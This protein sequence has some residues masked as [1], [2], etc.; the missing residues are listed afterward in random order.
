MKNF[1]EVNVLVVGDIM[2][3]RYIC[4]TV[5]RISPE[6]PVPIVHVTEEYSTLGGSGNVVRNMRSLGANV[7]CLASIAVDEAGKQI[8]RYLEELKVDRKI[9]TASPVTIVKERIVAGERK[10]QMLRVDREIP[11]SIDSERAINAIRHVDTKFDVVV[12]SDYNKGLVSPELMEYLRNRY[13]TII[14]DPKP[15]N[16]HSYGKVFLMTPNKGEWHSMLISPVKAES[17]YFLVTKG[18][19]GM[20]LIDARDPDRN[21]WAITDIPSHPVEV[22]NPSGAGDTAL[23]VLAVCYAA[24][25]NLLES[26]IIANDCAGWVVT[27]P[28][29][30]AIEINEFNRILI[31]RG[32]KIG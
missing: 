15:W 21:N 26:S 5:S 9:I 16:L 19:K 1:N 32:F 2:L 29:T 30:T 31:E 27:Q 7:T 3:D 24:G 25:L 10:T 20:E 23:A 22:F 13:D 17:D 14:V 18:K 11:L 28:G 6:A 4:G 12:V 8:S